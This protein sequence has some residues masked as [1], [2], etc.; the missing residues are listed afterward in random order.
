MKGLTTLVNKVGSL[1]WQNLEPSE[2]MDQRRVI[3]IVKSN[4]QQSDYKIS[5]HQK[6][7]YC[8]PQN[9]KAKAK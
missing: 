2:A 8:N 9:A 3:S 4:Y 6:I 1:S 5:P 7:T